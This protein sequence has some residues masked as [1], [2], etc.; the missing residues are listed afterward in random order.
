MYEKKRRQNGNTYSERERKCSCCFFF[1]DLYHV[2]D[3]RNATHNLLKPLF[4][5]MHSFDS[6]QCLR[7]CPSLLRFFHNIFFVNVVLFIWCVL[8]FKKTL[9][10]PIFS[11]F[12]CPVYYTLFMFICLLCSR[13]SSP[14]FAV[15]FVVVSSGFVLVLIKW[16]RDSIQ[17]H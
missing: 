4:R 2:M 12:L 16:V 17:T 8:F 13:D 3:N 1:N 11:I 7:G 15:D 6:A 10:L 9:R 14:S 5:L